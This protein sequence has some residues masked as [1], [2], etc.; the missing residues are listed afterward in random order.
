MNFNNSFNL[1]IVRIVSVSIILIMVFCGCTAK[2]TA[3]PSVSTS[4]IQESVENVEIIEKVPTYEQ[5][6]EMLNEKIAEK[7]FS[8]NSELLIL[9]AFDYVYKNYDSWNHLYK[10]IP[11]KEEFLQNR[12]IKAVEVVS[13]IAF[14]VEGTKEAENQEA[15]GLTSADENNVPFIE[16]VA[17]PKELADEE[18]R[19]FS[20][21]VLCHELAHALQGEYLWDINI[22]MGIKHSLDYT[23]IEGAATFY[24]KFA[25]TYTTEVMGGWSICNE[26]ESITIEYGKENGLGYLVYLND[27]EKLIYL[28]DFET[29]HKL[30]RGEI[31]GKDL[32]KVIDDKYG[33]GTTVKLLDLFAKRADIYEES[34]IGKK[35]FD[36]SVEIE[37]LFLGCICQDI[38]KA[39][40][41]QELELVEK[42]YRGYCEK[43]MPVVYD[44]ND[45]I[46]T[47]TV[48]ETE[49]VEKALKDKKAKL[50]DN[51]KN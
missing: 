37:N 17:L 18:E 43:N 30:D 19:N 51:K 47:K 14:Y 13:D 8:E 10:D 32:I 21:E 42:L 15:L 24:Q 39:K 49:M 45:N 38:E 41:K 4:I 25:N 28:S 46:I 1:K 44:K 2:K 16:I 7:D 31:K 36:Y 26:D 34:H 23:L 33:E 40:T 22:D 11:T 5:L 12:F 35:V 50:T 20:A 6:L 48:F 9:D 3:K 27:Y 29:M